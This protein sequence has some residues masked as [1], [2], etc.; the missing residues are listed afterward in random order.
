M[1]NDTSI[2][3][4]SSGT[5]K[6]KIHLTFFLF[7]NYFPND[8]S[9]MA[10]SHQHFS[11]ESSRVHCSPTISNKRTCSRHCTLSSTGHPRP[12]QAL[13]SQPYSKRQRRIVAPTSLSAS[14]HL[15]KYILKNKI[16]SKKFHRAVIIKVVTGVSHH[17]TPTTTAVKRASPFCVNSPSL[18]FRP[19]PS[20]GHPSFERC[21]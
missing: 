2:L 6:D 12:S 4:R 3:E 19:Q 1:Y 21:A 7:I 5:G 15:R 18:E 11:F 10:H 17:E 9:I 20:E 8:P 16:S 13:K 14:G